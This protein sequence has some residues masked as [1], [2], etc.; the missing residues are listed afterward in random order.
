MNKKD[1]FS[2]EPKSMCKLWYIAGYDSPGF[3]VTSKWFYKLKCALEYEN[4]VYVAL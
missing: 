3:G 4:K 2:K 1:G